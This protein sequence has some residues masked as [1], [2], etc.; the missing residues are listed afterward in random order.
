MLVAVRADSESSLDRLR[1][2]FEAWIEPEFAGRSPL[3]KPAFSV[4]LEPVPDRQ[5][6][7][8]AGPKPVPQLRYGSKVMARSRR[9]NDILHALV[10]V[11]GGLHK[12]R[13]DDGQLWIG[14]RPFVPGDA[15]VLVDAG[16][17]TLVNDRQLANS[18]IEEL[19]VWTVAIRP[20]GTV[21]V[22]PPVPHLA[23]DAAGIERPPDRPLGFELVGIVALREAQSDQADVVAD[24]ARRSFQNL[25]TSL[26]TAL[27][28]SGRVTTVVDHPMLRTQIR[29]LLGQTSVDLT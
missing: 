29:A 17:P 1:V 27:A 15:M 5:G 23:W 2:L 25:W 10:C 8:T 26:V 4:R 22:P 14:L 11:L 7:R 3:D 6:E 16:H 18:G 19:P 12:Q 13:C 9:P 21:S 20:D 28:E 24:I